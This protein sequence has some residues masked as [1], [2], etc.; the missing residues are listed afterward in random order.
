MK[1]RRQLTNAEGL[2]NVMVILDAIWN[3]RI[4]VVMCLR[5]QTPWHYSRYCIVNYR[6]VSQAYFSVLCC[7]ALFTG[8]FGSSGRAFDPM[9]VSVSPEVTFKVNDL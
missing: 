7:T 8:Y 4:T 6:I 2:A 9:C 3:C 1:I 5:L